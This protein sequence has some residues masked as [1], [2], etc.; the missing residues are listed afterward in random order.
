LYPPQTGDDGQAE[1]AAE[2]SVCDETLTKD[3]HDY[4]GCAHKTVG[5]VECQNW[6]SQEPHK[7]DRFALKFP[8]VG[9]NDHNYCRNP[10]GEETIW[11]YTMDPALRWDYCKP[12][13]V[14][15]E[16][17]TGVKAT[18][19]KSIPATHAAESGSG[20]S[21]G[22]IIFVFGLVALVGR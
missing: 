16:G 6:S 14:A 3:G 5:G 9:L 10:D 1:T 4:R 19:V 22:K 20:G 8:G 7:Q 17:A 15:K 18:K 2:T 13:P 12:E 11:C 21:A